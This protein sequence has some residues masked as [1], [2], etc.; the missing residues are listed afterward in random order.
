MSRGEREKAK[1]LA[2]LAPRSNA[3]GR[4]HGFPR[5]AVH[6]V[7]GVHG[8]V[9]AMSSGRHHCGSLLGYFNAYLHGHGLVGALAALPSIQCL[10][11]WSS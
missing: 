8:W 10:W 3:S 11:P 6:N 5:R 2:M 9:V 4:Q 1:E 7:L